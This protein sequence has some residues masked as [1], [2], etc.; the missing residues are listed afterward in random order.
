MKILLF[1]TLICSCAYA[2]DY[3]PS[4][5]DETTP[6]WNEQLRQNRDRINQLNASVSAILP[7]DLS[8]YGT[9]V[10]NQLGIIGGGTGSST[11]QGAIDNITIPT[12][13]TNGYVWTTNATHGYWQQIPTAPT[14][15]LYLVSTTS[16][17]Y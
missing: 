11:A 9:N 17:T 5:A 13:G 10:N 12:S 6:Q 1:L 7:I 8:L 3:V 15:Y 4:T 14:L 16:V 2:Q